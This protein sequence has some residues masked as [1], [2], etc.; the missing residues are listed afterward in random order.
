MAA[1]ESRGP[2]QSVKIGE[3]WN[4]TLIALEVIGKNA[5]HHWFTFIELWGQQGDIRHG[6]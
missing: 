3:I 6:L 1:C 4:I 2:G 5:A